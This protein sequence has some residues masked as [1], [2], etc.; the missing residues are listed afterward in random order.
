MQLGVY[1]VV[2]ARAA[3]SSR[4]QDFGTVDPM[5]L[6]KEI[7]FRLA[8]R[9]KEIGKHSVAIATADCPKRMAQYGKRLPSGNTS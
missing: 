3:I 2:S 6:N 1:D 4:L 5:P 8:I 7:S 9:S